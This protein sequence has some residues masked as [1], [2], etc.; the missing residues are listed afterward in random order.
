MIFHR[1]RVLSGWIEKKEAKGNGR[2]IKAGF[3]SACRLETLKIHNAA[4]PLLDCDNDG[5][6]RAGRWP[7]FARLVS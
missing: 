6:Y 3:L 1:K 7:R 5:Q 4:R 2:E